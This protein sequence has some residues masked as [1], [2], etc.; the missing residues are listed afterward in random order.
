MA[1]DSFA[2]IRSISVPTWLKLLIF[3]IV[4]AVLT[5]DLAIAWIAVVNPLH[6]DWFSVS[7]PLV[8]SLLPLLLV[9]LLLAFSSRGVDTIRRKTS[10]LLL[11]LVPDA[12]T[13]SLT[14]SPQFT[15]VHNAQ[16]NRRRQAE[17]QVEVAHR[18]G[19]FSCIYRINFPELHSR[20][21]KMHRVLLVVELKVRQVNMHLCVP[22]SEF[23]KFCARS[24][25]AGY[26]A[27]RRA[28][29]HTLS[30]AERAGCKVNSAIYH[31]PYD[32]ETV[33]TAVVVYRE[34]SE[35]FFTDAAEQL[36]WAQ[37][38]VTMLKGFVEEGLAAALQVQ[39]FTATK[40]VD[41]PLEVS[42]EL[43]SGNDF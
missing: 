37:D 25:L 15:T 38:M 2:G 1:L 3:L 36:F 10:H 32:E 23:D 33:Q 21:V 35:D 18:P 42:L 13:S 9:I 28:F 19:D 34:L 20:P 6:R 7:V 17:T 29:D 11:R 26:E 27:F 43:P 30:G 31:F 22:R 5:T 12:I 14:W 24:E 16:W 39:W 4:V 8:G 41:A 40:Q